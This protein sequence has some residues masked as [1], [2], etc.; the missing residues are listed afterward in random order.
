MGNSE[1][2]AQTVLVTGGSGFLGTWC[3]A[4]LLR[5]GYRVRTTVRDLAREPEVRAG[6]A[7][8]TD[9]DDRLSVVAADLLGDDGWAEAIEGCKYVLH[10]ASPF[11]QA[12]PKDPD[13]LIVPAREGTL[14]ILR[15]SLD[16]GVERVVVTSSV[17]A[18]SGGRSPAP[19]TLTERD[20]SDPDNPKL[21]PYA[22]SK[23]LAEQAAWDLVRERGE[24]G[25]L[26][27]VNPGAI[28]GPV[29]TA[30][31]SSSLAV[32]ERLLGG[33]PGVPKIGFSFVDVRDVA[34]LHARA[35][36]AP[37]AGGER[38]IA[39][40]RFLW[41]S[42]VA[43]VLR[44]RLGEAA[45]KVPSRTVPNLLVRAMALVDPPVRSVVRQLG[46]KVEYSS[47]QAETLL[48]WSPRPVED[49]VVD[50]ARSLID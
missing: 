10:V 37:E 49:T 30:G 26:A 3:V 7:S 24:T 32:I 18:V 42:E 20:W 31:R 33:M 46:R 17:A 45:A 48:G 40:G 5:R 47:E 43:A 23:T 9:G 2:Q 15:A 21:T 44:D 13:E 11:P 39:V 12:Q 27:V 25:K 16:A 29:L 4:D 22:R 34:D 41:M 28:L 36:T 19:G 6:L 38:F 14:R 50:C 8:V 1:A 35:M